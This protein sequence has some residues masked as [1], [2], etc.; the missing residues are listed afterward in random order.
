V[1]AETLPTAAA[2]RSLL[3]GD[4]IERF[5]RTERWVH[6]IQAISF[7][8]LL[9]SGFVLTLPTFASLIGNRELVREIHLTCSFLFVFGPAVVAL[10]ADRTSMRSDV[11]AVDTW[12]SDDL[13]WLVPF[14]IL[15]LFGVATPPQGRFNAG[16]KLNA[17]FVVWCTLAFGATGLVMWQNRRFSGD[18]VSRSMDIHNA[19]AYIALVA[20][21]GHLFLA[22]VYPKTR[23]ALRAIT[24]GWVSTDWAESHHA[25]WVRSFVPSRP[26]PKYD[27]ARAVW[28]TVI[29]FLACL[30]AVRVLFFTI[31]AN[32]TDKVTMRLYDA[33]AWPGAAG[34]HPQTAVHITDWAGLTYGVACVAAWLALDRLRKLRA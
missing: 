30:F 8:V 4:R 20:F 2:V 19:L 28:Q 22:T 7:L 14:P 12:D 16:Q 9:G 27:A 18:L 32:V 26:A 23:H 6:W 5:T 15:R 3:P 1:T 21:L 24:E 34:I 31:G 11:R 25:K 17:I 33:T 29:G 13:R 10:S